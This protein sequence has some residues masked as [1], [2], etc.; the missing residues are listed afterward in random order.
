MALVHVSWS[1]RQLERPNLRPLQTWR[2]VDQIHFRNTKLKLDQWLKSWTF[3]SF[4]ETNPE[5]DAALNYAD[6]TTLF[7]VRKSAPPPSKKHITED[8]PAM[9][10]FTCFCS[11][12]CTSPCQ[13]AP[14][15]QNFGA[16]FSSETCVQQNRWGK[17]QSWQHYAPTSEATPQEDSHAHIRVIGLFPLTRTLHEVYLKC[18][19]A[20]CNKETKRRTTEKLCAYILYNLC[21]LLWTIVA[22]ISAG[23]QCYLWP[24]PKMAIDRQSLTL[25][26]GSR[27]RILR[28]TCQCLNR[29]CCCNDSLNRSGD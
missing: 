27:T 13:L 20:P 29:R 8:T 9:A 18:M 11:C 23:P 21:I 26:N 6:L 22:G 16:C 3:P 15:S 7:G 17:L 2:G 1:P 24:E 12:L 14:P 5:Q 25:G 4:W 28:S 10:F 19:G